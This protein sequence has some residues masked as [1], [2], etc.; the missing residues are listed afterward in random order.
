VAKTQHEDQAR[1]A[2][3]A[4]EAPLSQ[5]FKP[6]SSGP[7]QATVF[8][9]RNVAGITA[10]HLALAPGLEFDYAV[11]D[12]KVVISTSL[13][14]IAAV[15]NPGRALQDDKRY[16]LTLGDRP[17]RVTSL[18]FLDFSQL[19][20]LGEQTGLTSGARYRTL[21]PD[22]QRIRAVGLSSSSG[23]TD[24]TAELFLQIT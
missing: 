24:S 4:L 11:F 22:L 23:E 6:P 12:G 17:S 14:G 3:A 21:R 13:A 15:R 19:L 2:M 18:L 7:G 8:S 1:T 16:K 5:L 20:T 9:D 10:H